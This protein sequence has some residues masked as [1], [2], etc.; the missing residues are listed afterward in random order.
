MAFDRRF[1]VTF[2]ELRDLFHQAQIDLINF[3]AAAANEMVVVPRFEVPAD[4]I[5][6]VSILARGSQKDSATGQIFQY[7]VNRGKSHAFEV[8]S[9]LCLHLEWIEYRPLFQKQFDD[10]PNFGR[11]P[12]AMAFQSRD[13][14]LSGH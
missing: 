14:I 4:E 10:R 1:E 9:Q 12:V 5:A 11:D 8:L 6:Q 13:V 2:D 3:P 7:P